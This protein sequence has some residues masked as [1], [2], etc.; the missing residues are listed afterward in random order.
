[1]WVHINTVKGQADKYSKR[2]IK[3][4]IAARKVQNITMRPSDH[5]SMD[6]SI[7]HL[8]N[9]PITRVDIIAAKDILG[10]NLGSLKG[11]TVRHPNKHVPG[12]MEGVPHEIM[13]LHKNVTLCIDI[14]FINKIPFLVTISRNL[15]FRMVED[16][17]NRQV[18]TI[19]KKLQ[20]LVKLYEHQ[21]FKVTTI[22][23]DPEFKPIRSE[24]PMLNCCGAD[25][26]I[27]DVERF[28]RTL[29]DRV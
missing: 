27:P 3:N 5:E 22:L 29:K 21:G 14:M 11:K 24:F 7:K 25:E 19:C 26:H 1:M 18:P 20:S 4:A 9:C 13:S 16:L 10:P 6:I 2:A 12:G 23:A 15:K 17:D 28:I 8:A